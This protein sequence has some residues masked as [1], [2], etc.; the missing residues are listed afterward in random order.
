[1]SAIAVRPIAPALG[2]EVQGIDIAAP[3]DDA[4]VARLRRALLDHLVIFFRG[5]DLTPE[6]HKAFAAGFGR[7][8]TDVFAPVRVP[9]ITEIRR[10]SRSLFRRPSKDERAVSK[11][12]GRSEN[13]LTIDGAANLT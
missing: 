13:D 7:L 12:T 8:Q 5:Q 9:T 6:R 3:L 11:G 2:A 10:V 4:A 1:M